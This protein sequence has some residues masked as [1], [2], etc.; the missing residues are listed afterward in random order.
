MQLITTQFL[1]INEVGVC[2]NELFEKQ[3]QLHQYPRTSSIDVLNKYLNHLRDDIFVLVEHPYVDKVYRD[4][5]YHYYS[6]KNQEYHRDCARLSFFSKELKLQD[7]RDFKTHDEIKESYLGFTIIRPTFPQVIGRSVISPQAVKRNNFRIC[8]VTVDVTSN[9]LKTSVTGFPHASQNSETITC[10]ETTIWCIM[11]Y[12][13]MRYPEYRPTL[14][15]KIGALLAS[16]SF[17]RLLPSKGLTAQQISFALRELGFGVK[18]Y[19]SDAYGKEFLKLLKMYIESGIPVVSAIQNTQGIGHAQ[20]IIGRARFTDADVDALVNSVDYG[21]NVQVYDFEDINVDYIFMDDNH[22]PYMHSKLETPSSFYTQSNWAGCKIK[23]FI[24]P[25]YS[26]IYM[27]AGEARTFAKSVLKRYITQLNV[28]KD[29]DVILKVFL[30]SSRSY[31][32]ELTANN[33][34][35]ALPRELLLRLPMPKFIWVAELST[36]ELIKKNH[37]NGVFI[38]DATE[39]NRQGLIAGLLGNYYLTENLNEIVQINVP[40][41]PFKN[42]NNNLR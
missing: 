1:P 3:Y 5:Y 38:L 31:K 25:L 18:I 30:A 9:S 19:S 11:D 14:P 23:S 37:V 41:S 40:L 26:K 34:L 12:F 16:Q 7:F 6:S 27:D 42:Y 8:S 33:S 36:K 22:P 13:G 21:N 17:E 39:T 32:N 10:A 29:T 35:S 24:V 4:S 20:S 15:S 2:L 28:L